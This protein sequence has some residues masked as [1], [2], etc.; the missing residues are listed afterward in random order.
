MERR[1]QQRDINGAT[2]ISDEATIICQE[3]D[4]NDA[5]GSAELNYV[6]VGSHKYVGDSHEED[7]GVYG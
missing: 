1:I 5:G 6:V 3:L 2:V 7:V 4:M